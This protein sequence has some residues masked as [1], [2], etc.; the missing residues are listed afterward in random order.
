MNNQD[1]NI[2]QELN[3]FLNGESDINKA[4]AER[5]P[6]SAPAHLEFAVKQMARKDL[7]GKDLSGKDLSGK[8]FSNKEHPETDKSSSGS[9]A[10]SPSTKQSRQYFMPLTLAASVLIAL[11]L[12]VVFFQDQQAPTTI[13]QKPVN[14]SDV[15]SPDKKTV[16]SPEKNANADL[17]L[18]S[19]TEMAQQDDKPVE[20][21]QLAQQRVAPATQVNIANDVKKQ[22]L[23]KREPLL[24]TTELAE[25]KQ[26][27]T[28]IKSPE[29]NPGKLKSGQL[30]PGQQKLDGPKTD[31]AQQPPNEIPAHINEL[32]QNTHASDQKLNGMPPQEVLQSW[33]KSQWVEQVKMLQKQGKHELAER[34]V[35]AYP[36]Y[37]PNDSIKH[38]LQP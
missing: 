27:N 30:E 6:L 8:N 3:D 23:E 32:L 9:G 38:L 35:Q 20:N 28:K 5:D 10:Q 2:D 26:S 33:Q 29:L 7:S 36:D 34:Y 19:N 31:L 13:A 4:Y 17:E 12:T 14:P 21:N 1:D 22:S 24:N 37:F 11:T 25:Q 15:A 16:V 18:K